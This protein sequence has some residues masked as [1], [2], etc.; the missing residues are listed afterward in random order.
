MLHD[1][2]TSWSADWG[3]YESVRHAGI[4]IIP[5]GNEIGL[6]QTV[7]IVDETLTSNPDLANRLFRWRHSTRW[8]ELC[9][10]RRNEAS[11]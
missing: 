1:A 11:T 5:S 8:S 3:V 9:P 7:A 2:W 6:K 4:L 10:G